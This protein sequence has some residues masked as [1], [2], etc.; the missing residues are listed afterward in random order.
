MNNDYNSNNFNSSNGY[1][2]STT[3]Y[4]QPFQTQNDNFYAANQQ[5][6]IGSNFCNNCG[7]KIQPG[8][9]FCTKCG[10]N[11]N[12]SQ[13]LNCE[14]CGAPIVKGT[15]FCNVCGSPVNKTQKMFCQFCGEKYEAGEAFCKKCGNKINK[16]ESFFG[17][18]TG[19]RSSNTSIQ[20]TSMPN[21]NLPNSI[22]GLHLILVCIVLL[23]FICS[24]M[25]VFSFDVDVFGYSFNNVNQTVDDLLA[26]NIMNPFS[27]VYEISELNDNIKFY[28][29]L[30]VFFVIIQL[31]AFIIT[32][33][34]VLHPLIKPTKSTLSKFIPIIFSI[35]A[36]L[37]TFWVILIIG[38]TIEQ[39]TNEIITAEPTFAA[40]AY[41]I[42]AIALIVTTI[43]TNKKKKELAE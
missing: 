41:I 43:I 37:Y 21:Y 39:G 34:V 17:S 19:T 14:Q 16:N 5:P 18:S 10:A 3:S 28:A 30:G 2:N 15:N 7:N 13:S 35:C 38:S 36:I 24:L 9:K 1:S 27:S 8:E 25:P 31:I 32:F 26:T 22:K 4:N 23:M 29:E 33:I 6:N 20:S 42:L 40:W 12:H 11:L